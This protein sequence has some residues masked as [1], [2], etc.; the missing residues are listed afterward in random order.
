VRV[1]EHEA[2]YARYVMSDTNSQHDEQLDLDQVEAEL[3]EIELM[4][5]RLDKPNG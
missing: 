5:E 2:A 1:I 4:L 3:A